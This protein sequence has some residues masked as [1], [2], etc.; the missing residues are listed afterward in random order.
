MSLNLGLCI[1]RKLV[2]EGNCFSSI[3]KI[4]FM[5]SGSSSFTMRVSMSSSVCSEVRNMRLRRKPW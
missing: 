1:Q 2:M 5:V 3:E 4:R